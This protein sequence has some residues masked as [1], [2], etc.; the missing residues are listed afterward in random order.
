MKMFHCSARRPAELVTNATVAA[1]AWTSPQTLSQVAVWN[2]PTDST[3]QWP[4]C[5]SLASWQ[6]E[7]RA[8]P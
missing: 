2:R 5:P 3:G 8:Q 6:G 1:R 4:G 7:V